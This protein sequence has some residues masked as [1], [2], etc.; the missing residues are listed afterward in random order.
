MGWALVPTQG[1]AGRGG[2]GSLRC[3]TAMPEQALALR[4]PC[5]P[6]GS[7]RTSAMEATAMDSMRREK[8]WLIKRTHTQ[9]RRACFVFSWLRTQHLIP[10]DYAFSALGLLWCPAECAH[11]SFTFPAVESPFRSHQ[12]DVCCQIS[13]RNDT[14]G[15][16]FRES[17]LAAKSS[18]DFEIPPMAFPQ[19]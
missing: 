16:T 10:D 1:S 12:C 6:L 9:N 8:K 3:L 13:G 5:P 19:C 15:V 4:G 17:H 14:T 11:C 2:L 18:E 7:L